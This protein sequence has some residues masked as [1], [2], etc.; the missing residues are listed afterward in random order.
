MRQILITSLLMLMLTGCVT[1]GTQGSNQY[2]SQT[3]IPQQPSTVLI[4]TVGNVQHVTTTGGGG[5]AGGFATG[6]TSH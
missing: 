5:F 4:T 2:Y 3:L 1:T 6:L